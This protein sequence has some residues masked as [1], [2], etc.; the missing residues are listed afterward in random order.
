MGLSAFRIP[1]STGVV[2]RPGRRLLLQNPTPG[3]GRRQRRVGADGGCVCLAP[4]A[5]FASVY[6]AG[7]NTHRM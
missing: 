7:L 1:C 4:P 6:V 3:I 2:S 5:P